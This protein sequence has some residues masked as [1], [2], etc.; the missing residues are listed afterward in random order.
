MEKNVS[1]ANRIL[2]RALETVTSSGE[3]KCG[4]APGTALVTNPDSIPAAT[5][6]RLEFLG[7]LK[8]EEGGR[9]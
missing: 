7:I 2:E 6:K 4:E 9:P 8:P 1:T 3:C 5:R